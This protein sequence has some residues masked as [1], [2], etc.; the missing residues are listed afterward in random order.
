M[1]D[2]LV[3]PV[4]KLFKRNGQRLL[5]GPTAVIPRPNATQA[6]AAAICKTFTATVKVL[7][8]A[9]A[10]AE[11]WHVEDE[12]LEEEEPSSEEKG[13]PLKRKKTP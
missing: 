9:E 13:T 6:Q 5:L 2:I 7:R 4:E 8:A 10:S 3:E 1:L 12:R 11:A